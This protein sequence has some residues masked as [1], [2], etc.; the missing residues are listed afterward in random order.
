MS[1]D[2][3]QIWKETIDDRFWENSGKP[4]AFSDMMVDEIFGKTTENILCSIAFDHDPATKLVSSRV[5]RGAEIP[6]SKITPEMKPRF[7]AAMIKE[8]KS[9]L[10]TGAVTIISP[11]AARDIERLRPDRIVPSR[12]VFREKPGEGL[13]APSTAK[14]RWCVLGHLDPDLLE[15]ERAA[16]TPQTVSIMTFLL[17]SASLQ[18]PVILGDCSTAFMQSDKIHGERKKGKLYSKLPPGGIP[19]E[20]GS[21][22]P[23][24]SLIQLNTAVYGLVNAPSSWRKTIVRGIE[25]LGYRRSCYDPCV[26]CRM[27][28][29]GPDGHILLD[30]DDLATSGNARH[31]KSMNDLQ[32]AFKFGKWKSIY[33]SEAD[34]AGRTIIQYKDYSFKVHQA[35]FVQERLKPIVIPKGRKSDKKAETTDGEKSQL[36]AV[37]G[38][39]NWV[40]RETRADVSGLASL[41]MSRINQSTVQDLCD[42][43]ECVELLQKTP[44][45]GI[46]I[47]HI[48]LSQVRWACVQDASWANAPGDK[49]QGGFLVGATT[50]ELA[51]NKPAPFALIS[52]RSHGL[53]RVCAS[54]LAAETQSMSESLA[55][56]EWIRG[57]FGELTDPSFSILEWKSRTRNRGLLVAGRSVD[58]N[59]ELPKVLSIC[60]AKS[61][62][63]HLHSETA[64][65]TADRRTA[66]E[67]QII[68]AS[69][70]SQEADVRWVD[71]TGMYADALTKRGGNV[72]LLQ[73]LLRT[74]RI[75][76]TEE[77][78]TLEK[79]RTS[80]TP[81]S[82]SSKTYTDPAQPEDKVTR[83]STPKGRKPKTT[84]TN[85]NQTQRQKP[86][87][88]VV[89]EGSVPSS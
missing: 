46:I 61:L 3:E 17:V 81:R 80:A 82:S 37:W 36:R 63:D 10:A 53:P 67:I 39:I 89:S 72:P 8:W 6:M 84:S 54:T 16:P 30:V 69:L 88:E 56:V 73:T 71:H 48:P 15:L 24:G 45:L 64:G 35:K 25:D 78:A 23:E 32:K 31:D 5:Q 40:Q 2:E 87:E 33:M 44:D 52:F 19:L 76:I 22:V 11:E 59:R 12:H 21:W 58:P 47:P 79:H 18:R 29:D 13:G 49:S 50:T 65:C 38:S 62:Y 75:A 51:K 68:R 41:G 83:K 55:E 1:I 27:T 28:K 57:L 77:S 43:N 85:V 9:I 4:I 42:A 14:A 74:A 34:Y 86:S 20:D 70:D 60:D 66:I 7:T 26:F